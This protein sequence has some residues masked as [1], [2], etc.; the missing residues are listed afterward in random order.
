[1]QMKLNNK[2]IPLSSI[3]NIG[4]AV[5]TNKNKLQHFKISSAN[6]PLFNMSPINL[7]WFDD[8]TAC[9]YIIAIGQMFLSYGCLTI[10]VDKRLATFSS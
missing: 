4:V 10:D 9:P 7:D 6:N 1:M 5:Q 3:K 8:D 2:S